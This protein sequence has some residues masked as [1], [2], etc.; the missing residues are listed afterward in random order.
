MKSIRLFSAL[1]AAGYVLLLSL[2]GWYLGRRLT[3]CPSSWSASCGQLGGRPKRSW[4]Y[5]LAWYLTVFSC[6]NVVPPAHPS[7][8]PDRLLRAQDVGSGGGVVLDRARVSPVARRPDL[9][10]LGHPVGTSGVLRGCHLG[11]GRRDPDGDLSARLQCDLQRGV[12]SSHVELFAEL[13][14]LAPRPVVQVVPTVDREP[15][16]GTVD[17]ASLRS[18]CTPVVGCSDLGRGGLCGGS[19]IAQAARA[20]DPAAAAL[21]RLRS[22][23]RPRHGHWPCERPCCCLAKPLTMPNLI[24][25][26]GIRRLCP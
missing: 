6:H 17:S 21:D 1:L 20:C 18:R 10:A 13:R 9:S 15:H 25:V 8:S 3:L 19:V 11:R 12:L 24:L 16:S 22:A 14:P 7:P 26:V 2:L 4:G 23:L 5:Q